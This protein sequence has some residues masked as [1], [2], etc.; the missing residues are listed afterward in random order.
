MMSLF[1][2]QLIRKRWPLGELKHYDHLTGLSSAFGK[3]LQQYYIIYNRNNDQK[4]V[5]DDEYKL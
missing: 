4:F 3:E 2:C 1:S 5:K